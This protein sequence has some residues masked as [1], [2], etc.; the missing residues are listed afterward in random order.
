MKEKCFVSFSIRKKVALVLFA[1][2]LVSAMTGCK[3]TG[4]SGGDA[5]PG[6]V[7][8]NLVANDTTGVATPTNEITSTPTPTPTPVVFSVPIDEEHFP[9]EAFRKL[10]K[11]K[12]DKIRDGIL[13]QDDTDRVYKMD[14]REEGVSVQSLDG[15]GYFYDLMY[16]KC[17][18][19]QLTSLDLRGATNLREVEVGG[20]QL[21]SLNLSGLTKLERLSCRYNQLT[22]LDLDGLVSLKELD[23]EENQLTDLDVSGLT[24]LERLTCG[25]RVSVSS[26]RQ[27]DSYE[28]RCRRQRLS[29]C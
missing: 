14:L 26:D 5:A 28:N 24:N 12:Y 25:E 16:L 9:D 18:G 27:A 4:S 21:T 2:I 8:A 11:S 15:I 6:T 19:N 7:S 13:T 3:I 22:S 23:V 20:N 10:V 17:G 1:A 29:R